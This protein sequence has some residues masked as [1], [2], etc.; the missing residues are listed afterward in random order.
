MSLKGLEILKL[1]TICSESH[2]QTRVCEADGCNQSTRENKAFCTDHVENQPY[3]QDLMRRMADREQED[4][5]VRQ[6]GSSAV[7]LKGIT[8]SE[9]LLHLRQNGPRTEDRLQRE[10][11]IEKGTLYSYIVALR[12]NGIVELGT[13][14]RGCTSIALVGVD[15]NDIIEEEEL[16][17]VG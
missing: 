10:L 15:P 2:R 12:K 14:P 5:K 17:D 9:I 7:N 11:Q 1:Q 13:T 8:I 16:E 3:V 4:L 6:N